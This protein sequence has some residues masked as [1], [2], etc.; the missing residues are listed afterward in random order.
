MRKDKMHCERRVAPVGISIGV[1]LLSIALAGCGGG[2]PAGPS[3]PS[4]PTVSSYITEVRDT[5][6]SIA[7]LR[8]GSPPA[9]G[10]GPGL[11]VTS[12][13]T[14]INGGT[15]QAILIA[16]A[17]ITVAYVSIGGA[18][19]YWELRLPTPQTR[20]V[21]VLSFA[22]T[23]PSSNFDCVYGAASGT[24]AVS[25]PVNVP[26][27]GRTVGSGDVQ[28]SLSWNAASDVDLHVVDPTGEEIYY[29]HRTSAS[30]GVL[31]LDSNAACSIDGAQNENITWPIGRAPA[32]TYTV[33]V[34]YW[35]SC[36]VPRT[37]YVVRVSNG[38]SSQVY[39]GQFTGS[40]DG[41]GSGDGRFITTFQR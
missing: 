10:A 1:A 2:N 7:V 23:L 28:V 12:N 9:A 41:G 20:I 4:A 36:G 38:R 25:V 14:V 29:G 21:L 11:Q 34:D 17:P 6:G 30:G 26:T 35:S 32:G 40:G 3:R 8:S 19:S 24:G 15:S 37:D 31:D 22:T 39:Q 18:G 13:S 33:R 16:T 5:L 27:Q